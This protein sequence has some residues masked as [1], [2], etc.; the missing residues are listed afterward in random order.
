M[1][2]KPLRAIQGTSPRDPIIARR[3]FEILEAAN[4]MAVRRRYT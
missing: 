3:R 4:G 1:I 2:V